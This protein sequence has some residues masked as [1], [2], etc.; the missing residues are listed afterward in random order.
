MYYFTCNAVTCIYNSSAL[1][2]YANDATIHECVRALYLCEYFHMSNTI[3]S[4][5]AVGYPFHHMR[6]EDIVVDL[7]THTIL[8][9]I[10]R[11]LRYLIIWHLPSIL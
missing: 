8:V 6:K 11:Y 2:G 1:D 9:N 10:L 5:Y 3:Y 7:C 4:D